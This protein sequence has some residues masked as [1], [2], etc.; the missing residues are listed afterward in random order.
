ME[1]S[2]D[3]DGTVRKDSTDGGMSRRTSGRIA[4][5]R[6]KARTGDSEQKGEEQENVFCRCPARRCAT[7]NSGIQ[8]LQPPPD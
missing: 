1:G 3:R 8:P 7:L 4:L 2:V 6:D 5:R